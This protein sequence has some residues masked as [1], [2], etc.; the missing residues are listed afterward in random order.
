M[1]DEELPLSL[2]E[3]VQMT[4]AVKHVLDG[5]KLRQVVHFEAQES[6]DREMSLIHSQEPC[7]QAEIPIGMETA[8]EQAQHFEM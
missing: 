2:L 7:V 5:Q 3:A 1:T 8:A 4:K 6:I